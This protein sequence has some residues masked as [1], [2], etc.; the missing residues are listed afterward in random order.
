MG[1][2]QAKH[3][4]SGFETPWG[5]FAQHAWGVWVEQRTKYGE[6]NQKKDLTTLA[7]TL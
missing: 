1:D 4:K 5:D 6:K 3:G 7:R 2:T